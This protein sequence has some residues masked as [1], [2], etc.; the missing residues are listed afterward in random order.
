[1]KAALPTRITWYTF[2]I[3]AFVPCKVSPA[4]SCV[5]LELALPGAPMMPADDCGRCG[6]QGSRALPQD[7]ILNNTEEWCLIHR[8]V[9]CTKQG[10]PIW[11]DYEAPATEEWSIFSFHFTAWLHILLSSFSLNFMSPALVL[12]STLFLFPLT[13]LA[14]DKWFFVM[15]LAKVG[16]ETVRHLVPLFENT[17]STIKQLKS[18]LSWRWKAKQSWKPDFSI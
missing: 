2:R 12:Q 13:A 15:N 8:P 6:Q 3:L 9:N 17:A 7:W 11:I 5:F 4:S 18:I 1:M 10:E 16:Y 14:T